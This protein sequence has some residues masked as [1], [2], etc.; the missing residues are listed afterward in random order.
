M[1]LSEIK[2][3]ATAMIEIPVQLSRLRDIA[4]NLWWSWSPSA[5]LLFERIDSTRWAH[6][7]NPIELLIDLEPDRW[8]ALQRD[9]DFI[10]AY[11]AVVEEFDAYMA[12]EQPTWYARRHP[13]GT[14]GPIAYFSTEFGWHESLQIYS[15][16]LGV[17]SG[18]HS[19]SAS[20]LGLPFIGLG[21]MYRHGYF[22]QTV[23]AEGQRAP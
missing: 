1:D 19:K 23:D 10:K 2:T 14:G 17:L 22:W 5:H 4:Y 11:R 12:P 21:L 9:A 3:R 16:G 13:E 7:R 8:H 18:D 15:G 6:Y 20:D